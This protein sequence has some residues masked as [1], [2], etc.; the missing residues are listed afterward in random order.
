MDLNAQATQSAPPDPEQILAATNSALLKKKK[1]A[2]DEANAS[3]SPLQI[4]QAMAQLKPESKSP[5]VSV[6][7]AVS[8]D[9]NWA[10]LCEAYAEKQI[11]G[12][13]GL[14]PSAIAAYQANAQEGNINTSDKNIPAGAQLFF[15]AD[16]GNGNNGHTGVSNGD[17]TFQAP[18]S[19]GGIHDFTLKDWLKYSGQ[20]YLGYAPPP[21]S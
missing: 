20:E 16:Q 7:K 12:R 1:Q 10:N 5:Q 21:K 17:G 6:G 8:S 13:E 3:Y 9:T 11:Y 18:L 19:D 15:N 14:Y 2:A 4:S